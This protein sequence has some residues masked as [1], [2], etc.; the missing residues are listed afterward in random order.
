MITCWHT[1]KW[2]KFLLPWCELFSTC[3]DLQVIILPFSSCLLMWGKTLLALYHS[4]SSRKLS[5]G[6][7]MRLYV[8]RALWLPNIFAWGT[9][10]C[11]CDRDGW[12]LWDLILSRK[13]QYS[14]F[15][16]Q[17]TVLHTLY[18]QGEAKTYCM[19]EQLRKMTGDR[20]VVGGWSTLQVCQRGGWVLFQA[21]LHLTTKER[22]VVI[23]ICCPWQQIFNSLCVYIARISPT[24]SGS[25]VVKLSDVLE[26]RNKIIFDFYPEL[27]HALK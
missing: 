17:F 16:L 2:L 1:T 25:S 3:T 8:P 10:S 12:C 26:I 7:G 21:L 11:R 9:W 13:H 27:P 5:R 24:L 23:V 19:E 20:C 18:S 15:T 6:L 22:Q 14:G 4:A